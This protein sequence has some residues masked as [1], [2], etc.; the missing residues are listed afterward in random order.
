[1]TRMLHSDL[2]RLFR[3]RGL[4]IAFAVLSAFVLAAAV[5][6]WHLS[7]R[8]NTELVRHARGVTGAQIDASA[9]VAAAVLDAAESDAAGRRIRSAVGFERLLLLPFGGGA[10]RGA[11]SGGNLAY[12]VPVLLFVSFSGA[13]YRTGYFKNLLT[14]PRARLHWL[15][16]KMLCALLAAAMLYLSLVPAAAA[17]TLILGNPLPNNWEAVF[18]YLANQLFVIFALM[19]AALAALTLFQKKT[20]ALLIGFMTAAGVHTV[21]FLLLDLTALL[22]FSLQDINLLPAAAEIALGK[23]MPEKVLSIGLPLI[24]VSGAVSAAALLRRDMKM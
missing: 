13:D 9:D 14:L 17:G 3:T 19:M 4:Y 12:I 16:S 24:A 6:T 20:P 22:P 8:S 7:R 10:G 21:F 23:Q 2:R 18:A 5:G 11:L 1:M 15:L